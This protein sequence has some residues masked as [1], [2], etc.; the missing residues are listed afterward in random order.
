TPPATTLSAIKYNGWRF[1]D[2]H[3]RGCPGAA[4]REDA[5]VRERAGRAILERLRAGN[6]KKRASSGLGSALRPSA[7]RP[8]TRSASSRRRARASTTRGLLDTGR[9]AMQSDEVRQPPARPASAS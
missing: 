7:A 6:Q 8:P 9:R 5:R 2:V 1:Q 3:G 4:K